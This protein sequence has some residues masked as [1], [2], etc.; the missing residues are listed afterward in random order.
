MTRE[1]DW[2]TL[3]GRTRPRQS[4][5]RAHDPD[6]PRRSYSGASPRRSGANRRWALVNGRSRADLG[7]QVS[8]AARAPT[9]QYWGRSISLQAIRFRRRARPAALRALGAAFQRARAEPGP[10]ARPRTGPWPPLAA[11]IAPNLP[12]PSEEICRPRPSAPIWGHAITRGRLRASAADPV[13]RRCCICSSLTANSIMGQQPGRLLTLQRPGRRRSIVSLCLILRQASRTSV[14]LQIRAR[15]RRSAAFC[16][17]P[18]GIAPPPFFCDAG[19]REFERAAR[20]ACSPPATVRVPAVTARPT[21]GRNAVIL[22][23]TDWHL[24]STTS[25]AARRQCAPHCW[26]GARS[27]GGTAAARP[28]AVRPLASAWV[29]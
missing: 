23:G 29:W 9:L 25:K 4:S 10:G 5:R 16:P 28:L 3:P 19:R 14:G 21:R 13:N 20:R 11:A 15:R 27:V 1:G 22:P 17:G 7:R 12:R 26:L 24:I 2:K 6:L 8:G 18:C